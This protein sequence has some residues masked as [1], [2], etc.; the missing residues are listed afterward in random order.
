MS[1]YVTGRPRGSL[2]WSG[3][4]T[5]RDNSVTAIVPLAMG[6]PIPRLGIKT[7]VAG[8]TAGHS[9]RRG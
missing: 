2:W 5:A 4:S 3:F 1:V 6:K 9:R 8:V 7:V